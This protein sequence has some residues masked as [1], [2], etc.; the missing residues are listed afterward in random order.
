MDVRGFQLF[1]VVSI[2]LTVAVLLTWILVVNLN[3]SAWWMKLQAWRQAARPERKD[4]EGTKRWRPKG[5]DL[6]AR[7][8]RVDSK[9]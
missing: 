4:L 3:W 6:N 2:P 7:Q 8:E 5:E 1:W 9:V